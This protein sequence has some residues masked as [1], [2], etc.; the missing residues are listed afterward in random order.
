[1]KF[2]ISEKNKVIFGWSTKCGCSHVK[3][4]FNYLENDIVIDKV[5]GL[6]ESNIGVDTTIHLIFY[7]LI[8]SYTACRCYLVTIFLQTVTHD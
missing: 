7:N 3:R 4:L 6:K 1:M 2:L 8:R 5:H